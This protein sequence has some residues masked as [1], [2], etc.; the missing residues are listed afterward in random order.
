MHTMSLSVHMQKVSCSLPNNIY[1][2]SH[3]Y[4]RKKRPLL[5]DKIM[6]FRQG[7]VT[8]VLIRDLALAL[9]REGQ[10][11]GKGEEEGKEQKLRLNVG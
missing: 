4:G 2:T 5:P 3:V 7:I 10:E 1:L 6:R 8:A 11:E 9:R